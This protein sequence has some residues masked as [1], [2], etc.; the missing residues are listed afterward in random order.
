MKIRRLVT[1][2]TG[3]AQEAI[4]LLSA[5]LAVLLFFGVLKVQAV[6]NLPADFMP[7]YLLILVAFSLFSIVSGAFLIREGRETT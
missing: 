1:T 7:L 4:G 6:F 5:V 3:V 2:V